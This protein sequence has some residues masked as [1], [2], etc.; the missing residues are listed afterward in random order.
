MKTLTKLAI[1]ASVIA[2]PVVGFAV[3]KPIMMR[4]GPAAMERIDNIF[5]QIDANKDGTITLDEITAVVD[6]RFDKVDANHDGVI[7]RSELESYLGRRAPAPR[8]DAV[9]KHFDSNGDGKIAKAEVEG[10]AKKVFAVFDRQDD[11]K[12]TKEDVRDTLPLAML[13]FGRGGP[14]HPPHGPRH[15]GPKPADA[16]KP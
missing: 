14:G 2:V 12:V 4:H 1:A 15:D 11:G 6:A 16:P 8:I 13:D 5:N 3:A 7:D 9:L 10:L